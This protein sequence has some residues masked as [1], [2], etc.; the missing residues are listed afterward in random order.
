MK[1]WTRFDVW[2]SVALVPL[3]LGCSAEV[4]STDI[5]TSGIY[6]EITITASGDGRSEVEVR[7]K[8]G[9]SS[10]N[11][12]L[13]LRGDDT[14]EATVEGVTKTLDERSS[15]T[16]RT[17]FDVDAEGTEFIIAFLRG[18]DDDGAPASTVTLP[19]PFTMELGAQAASRETDPVDF[20]WDPPATG[21]IRWRAEG[22]CIIS[23]DDDTT[24]DG[25]ASIP[26]GTID[27]FD[28]DKEETCPVELELVRSRRG[29]IDSAFTEGGRIE[30]R[31]VRSAT[32]ES[33]P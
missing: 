6:P 15:N 26:A 13:K 5:R 28:S 23:E 2:T 30:A 20:T 7:L 27:T 31:H 18:D 32:F 1:S 12:F 10:S 29:T 11:T 33:T 3:A 4:E 19:A 22:D 14:L 21:T 17:S 25:E 24:D 8:V 9:E 16:Y